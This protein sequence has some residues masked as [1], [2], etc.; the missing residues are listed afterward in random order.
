MPSK[1]DDGL[2][3]FQTC[4]IFHC[5]SVKSVRL[6][7]LDTPCCEICH[8]EQ[9]EETPFVVVAGRKVAVCCV[10]ASVYYNDM[11]DNHDRRSS[12]EG[13]DDTR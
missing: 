10:V 12:G 13:A 2:Y 5:D 4:A 1:Q 8:S 3:T 11:R 9:N 6:V 7:P